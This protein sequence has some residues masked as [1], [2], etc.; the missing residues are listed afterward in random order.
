MATSTLPISVLIPVRN[1]VRNLGRCLAA[2]AGWADEVVVVDSHSS[3]GTVEL[4][5]RAGA[6]VLQFDYRGGWP[7]KRQ[8]A[9]DTH[10]WRN[11][12]ILLLDAD[13]IITPALKAEIEAAIGEPSVAGYWLRFEI[14]F[15][16]TLLRHGDTALWK[17]SLFR[18]GRGRYEQRLA[19][20]DSSMSDIEI[21][22][23]VVVEG[24]TGRLRNAVRH[25]NFNSLDRYIAKHNEYS[26]WEAQVFLHGTS[27]ALRPTLFGNQ[28]QRRRW[29]KRRF[30]MLPGS[31][32]WRFLYVYILRMGFLDGR[33][34][35]I[36]AMFKFVQTFHVKAKIV[37][38]RE[39][40]SEKLGASNVLCA[41]MAAAKPL[42]ERLA[43]TSVDKAKAYD[44]P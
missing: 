29:L 41:N 11:D 3:D 23:H 31:P 32:L 30:L 22:E 17:L 40:A 37:E 42:D 7:K 24:A 15:L 39:T 44:L 25:E 1:E 26:N 35:L 13:E 4:A 19:S 21:H 9:L 5:K 33:A 14:L 38:L 16:G 12:W 8:W 43:A 20:Q 18:R 27:G 2:L 6:Q 10:R 28:A 34:G 36:Y